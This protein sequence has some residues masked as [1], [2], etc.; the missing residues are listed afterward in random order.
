MSRT[1]KRN[2]PITVTIDG[3]VCEAKSGATILEI[4]REND[5]YIPTMCYLT[6]VMPI[7]SCRMCV[8]DVEGV[9]GMILSCQERA[10][11]GAIIRT[12]SKELYQERQSIMKL[13]GVN[14]PLECGVCDKSGECDL[15]NK[16][17]EFDVAEQPYAAKDQHRPVQNWGFVSYDPAL[18]IMCEKCVRVSN[19]ITGND[20]LSIRSGGYKSTIVN[21]KMDSLDMSL[22]ESAAVCPVGAL[23]LS[24]FKYSTNAWELKKVP[25]SCSHCSAGCQIYYEVKQDKI[26][27]VT[28]EYEYSSI[29]NRARF[30]FDF[31]NSHVRKIPKAFDEAVEALKN[32]DS[33]IFTSK[34]SNEEALILQTLKEKYGF[35][36]IN[37]EAYAYQR[38]LEAYASISGKNLYS[39]TL[40]QLSKA[41][42]VIVLGTRI[43]DDHS[44]TKYHITMASKRNQA[45]VVYMHPIEDTS[46]QNMVTQFV[47]YEVGSEEGV[48]ALLAETLLAEI[49]IPDAFREILEDLDIGNLSAESNIGEEELETMADAFVRRDKRMLVIGPDLYAHH[50]AESIAKLLALLERYAG[51]ST[52]IIPPSTNT[53]GVALLCE[54]DEQT[55][56]KTVGYNAEADFVLSSLGEGDLDMPALNQQEGTFTTIDKRVVPTHVAV[57]YGGYVLNDIAN[58]MGVASRYTIDYTALLPVA[59]G[60]KRDYFDALPDYFDKSGN[61]HRGYQLEILNHQRLSNLDEV[62]ELDTYDGVVV[63]NC[64]TQKIVAQEIRAS[65]D[66]NEKEK[67]ELLGS[68]Q[69]ATAAKLKD[70]DVI[71]FTIGDVKFVRI[72]KEDV[73]MKGTIALN[74]VFD[75]GL[76]GALLSS[77]R[78]DRLN[79]QRVES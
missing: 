65:Q 30:D 2:Q 10:V 7:A 16:T 3:K 44:Q 8:V 64:D 25:A 20:V 26:Y 31:A 72:F 61:A 11:D 78:F 4:A 62:D 52:I 60:Y 1:I 43:N 21:N 42:A 75:T 55:E 5:I 28:N 40:D 17:L 63:Y 67:L 71:Q 6:K 48:A 15:Q 35:K 36:L 53:L 23:V 32:A 57:A 22:G 9:D 56:G 13:Y 12:N 49:D 54:L 76:R 70:G 47:K 50:R 73:S 68:R 74:P 34:I 59:K 19:E 58:A 27:R 51:F 77:Y 66:D 18:C 33:V 37:H 38:F 79:F 24:D 39:G 46:I 14:H 41:D 69:F 45:R 29:C